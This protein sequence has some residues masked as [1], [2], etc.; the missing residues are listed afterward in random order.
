[1]LK[2]AKTGCVV[3]VKGVRSLTPPAFFTL[4][5]YNMAHLS[6]LSATGIRHE[7]N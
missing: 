6:E 3:T 4:L 7:N 1:M 5:L 2:D